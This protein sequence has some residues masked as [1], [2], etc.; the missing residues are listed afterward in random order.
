MGSQI[1]KERGFT[2]IE[3]L[4]VIAIIALLAAILFPV[5]AKAQAK[6]KQTQCLS[7][8]RNLTLAMIMF[9]QDNQNKY[10]TITNPTSVSGN[11]DFTQPGPRR[12]RPTPATTKSSPARWTPTAPVMSATA[13]TACCSIPPAMAFRPPT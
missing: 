3:L 8:I 5:F 7:N 1:R 2:L 11:I 13:T 4:V 9:A 6:A 10:P 12:F